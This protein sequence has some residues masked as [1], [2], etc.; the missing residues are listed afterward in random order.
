MRA[1]TTLVGFVCLAATACGGEGP[2][3]QPDVATVAASIAAFKQVERP[4]ALAKL[5][6]DHRGAF[7]PQDLALTRLAA[8]KL[9]GC[10]LDCRPSFEALLA[11]P[12]ASDRWVALRAVLILSRSD[13]EALEPALRAMDITQATEEERVLV[14]RVLSR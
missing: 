3:E 5:V 7:G 2:T 14:E 13:K 6:T 12:D 10:G 11:S 4:A 1:W 9:A 8:T